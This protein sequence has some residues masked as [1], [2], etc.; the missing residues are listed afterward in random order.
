MPGDSGYRP[1][2]QRHHLIP[3]QVLHVEPLRRMIAVLGVERVGIHDFRRNGQM[4]PSSE[5]EAIRAGLP[6][7]RGPHR[8]YNELVIERV[9]QIEVEWS[10]D[11]HRAS[12][13]NYTA[14]MRLDLLQRALRR[15]F[16]DPRSW[17]RV[18]LNTRDPALDFSH[19]DAMAELFW[20]ETAPVALAG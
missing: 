16:L 1:E 20:S 7:H 9:G 10:R 14:L 12:Y 18:P 5:Q 2:Q 6:L 4:L 17:S 8:A 15:R 3:R 19:L 13:A 11:R